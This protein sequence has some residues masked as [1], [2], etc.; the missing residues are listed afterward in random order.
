MGGGREEEEETC[1]EWERRKNRDKGEGK[2]GMVSQSGREVELAPFNHRCS[3]F[4]DAP[5]TFV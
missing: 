3:L 4:A 2:R 5:H 1:N